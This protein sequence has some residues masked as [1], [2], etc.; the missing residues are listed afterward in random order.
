MLLFSWLSPLPRPL[1][2]LEIIP[3]FVVAAPR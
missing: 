1:Y 2:G 3:A